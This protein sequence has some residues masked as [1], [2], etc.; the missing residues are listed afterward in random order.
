MLCYCVNILN[1]KFMNHKTM[2]AE[3]EIFCY[4]E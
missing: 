3:T 2:R 1:L 4:G